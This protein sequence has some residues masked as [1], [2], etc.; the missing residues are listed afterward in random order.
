MSTK[1]FVLIKNQEQLDKCFSVIKELRPHLDRDS[2]L[3]IYENAHR[4]DDYNIIAIEE[5]GQFLALMGYRILYDFVRG[6]HLY[7]DDLVTTEK[8]RSRGLGAE[9]LS[10]AEILASQLNCASMRLC[11]GLDNN[12]AMKFYERNGW[13]QRSVAYVKKLKI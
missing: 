5:S 2:Y 11:T 13:V 7:I 10:H 1:K 8:A 9:L 6:R 12:K 4:M 3:Q